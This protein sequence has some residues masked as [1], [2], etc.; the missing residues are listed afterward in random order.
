MIELPFSDNEYDKLSL[1]V[2]PTLRR[3][4][5]YGEE[6]D[7]VAITKG[8]RRQRDYVGKAEVVSV[9][10]VRPEH[11]NPNFLKYDTQTPERKTT[12]VAKRELS[13]FYQNPI[14]WD[15]E[16]YLYW[17]KWVEKEGHR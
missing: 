13:S 7:V 11:L 12:R 3:R 17:L 9:E 1:S 10:V 16:I 15:E 5:K 8:E 2:F 4:E 6:G 14:E